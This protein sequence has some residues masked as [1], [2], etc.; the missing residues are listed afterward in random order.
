[1]EEKEQAAPGF[2]TCGPNNVQAFNARLRQQM[3]EFHAFA[4]ACHQLGLIDGL[5]GARIGPAGSLP[6]GGVVPN[7]S[8]AAEARLRARQADMKGCR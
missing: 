3:P 7:L 1:M 2:I 8:N 5:R 4:A 6:G